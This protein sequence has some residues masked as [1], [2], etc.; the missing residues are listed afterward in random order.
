MESVKLPK[1]A[2]RDTLQLVPND[3]PSRSL[4]FFFGWFPPP[5]G[6]LKVDRAPPPCSKSARE[7][8]SPATLRLQFT[9]DGTGAQETILVQGSI[10]ITLTSINYFFL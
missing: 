7:G 4:S 3:S 9:T 8:K 2:E 1:A 5:G 10:Q 6:K